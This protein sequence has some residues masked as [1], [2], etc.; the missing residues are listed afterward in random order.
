MKP[1][2]IFIIADTHFNHDKQLEFGRPTNFT[3]L[4]I[5]NWQKT[6][7]ECDTVFHLGDVIFSR[8]SELKDIMNRLPGR[9]ILVRGNHDKEQIEW[10]M[11]RGFAFACDAFEYEDTV[12]T[13][14]PLTQIPKYLNRN[15]HGHLH[16]D[17]H[18]IGECPMSEH[19]VLFSLEQENY[20]PQEYDEF[21]GR[22]TRWY[23]GKVMLLPAKLV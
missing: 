5:K 4:I 22:Q 12:F 10:Y 23:D 6:V 1:P 2:R 17:F 3:E 18:R 13:H 15:I 19:N 11:S 21:K 7:R 20:T 16:D 14:V 9:K 8:P